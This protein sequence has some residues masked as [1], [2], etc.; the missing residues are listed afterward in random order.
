[1]GEGVEDMF[2]SPLGR[3]DLQKGS[4]HSRELFTAEVP[5]EQFF[6][7]DIA[8]HLGRDNWYRTPEEKPEEIWHTLRLEN[9][10][11]SP[12]T[13]GPIMVLRDDTL[14]GQD[15]SH[16]TPAGGS[17]TVKVT[18][19]MNLYAE[20]SEVELS[21][22]NE[23]IRRWGDRYDRVRL[24]G[25]LLVRSH[26]AKAAELEIT[27]TLSGSLLDSSLEPEVRALARGLRQ[28]NPTHQLRWNQ[29]LEPG[30]ELV[31]DYEYE[32]LVRR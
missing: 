20:Q 29:R 11:S 32:V 7:W 1:M 30:E 18:K 24:K 2:R 22:G 31:I 16:Y 14:I 8:D 4:R 6:S 10:T 19:A 28:I 27:K 5:T 3:L 17:A 26:Q 25:T 21:R 9:T 15:L 23:D 13:T 12:W